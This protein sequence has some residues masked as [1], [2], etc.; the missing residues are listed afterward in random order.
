M[1]PHAGGGSASETG[2]RSGAAPSSP[3]RGAPAGGSIYKVTKYRRKMYRAERLRR[4][5]ARC[6]GPGRRCLSQRKS[7]CNRTPGAECRPPAPRK[8]APNRFVRPDKG[9]AGDEKTPQTERICTANHYICIA[10]LRSRPKAPSG[11]AAPENA[12]KN[13]SHETHFYH[14]DAAPHGPTDSTEPRSGMIFT[15]KI[16]RTGNIA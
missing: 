5:T 7:G 8:G 15:K 13:F 16:C 4:V 11:A 10:Q 1:P 3:L 6:F 2:R 12:L 9:A 14:P